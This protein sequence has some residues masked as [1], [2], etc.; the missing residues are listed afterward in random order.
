MATVIG[1][2][3]D[4]NI[5]A[6]FATA[7][8]ALISNQYRKTYDDDE[9]RSENAFFTFSPFYKTPVQVFNYSLERFTII[10]RSKFQQLHLKQKSATQILQISKIL[11]RNFL[12]MAVRSFVNTPCLK[13][14]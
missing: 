8:E 7:N 1:V 10:V 11:R 9:I 5:D 14:C 3:N 4:P 2:F 12:K 13:G 6:V